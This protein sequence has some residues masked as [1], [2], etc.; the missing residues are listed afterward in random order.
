MNDAELKLDVSIVEGI[1]KIAREAWDGLL[2]PDDSPFLEWDWLAA[3]EQSGS[4]ARK[5][6]WAPY[7]I[8]V[9]EHGRKR[10]IAA[11]PLYLKSHSMGEFVFDHGWAEAASGAGIDY[12]PKLLAG[13][14]FTPHTGRR[15]LTAP[16]Q[17]RATL[18]R[19]LASGL[20]QLCDDNKISSVHVNFCAPDEVAALADLGFLERHGYQFHWHNRGYRTFDD[21]LAQLKHKRRSAVR[22]ERAA[23][24]A[25]GIEIRVMA[26]DELTE[27]MFPAMFRVYLA[28]I[29][30]LYWGR[31]YLT[32]EFFT[33]LGKHFRRNMCFIGA[34]RGRELI[35][36]AVNL[37]KAGVLYGRYW[38]CFREVRFLHFNVCYYAGIEHCIARGLERYEPGAGGEYKW[39]RGFDPALT[40]SMHYLAHPGLRKA[41]ADFLKRERREVDRWIEAGNERSQLKPPPPS[42]EE[43][44]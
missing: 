7:H 43:T 3:L 13:V 38:G 22:H 44:Q 14:P 18:M 2:W 33:L 17:D 16:G 20:V 25:E 5:T 35:A 40:R 32:R 8:V 30:K 36:G 24:E 9:R 6:G 23:I 28:T 21:Y 26:G 41:V 19:V 39:L 12:Y 1:E 4:A 42:D 37:E 27:Q 15:L 11:C 31:Q 10:I 29:E 34:W